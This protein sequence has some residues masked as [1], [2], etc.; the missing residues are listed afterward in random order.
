MTSRQFD[1]LAM[2]G[3]VISFLK[4]TDAATLAKMPHIVALIEQYD[5]MLEELSKQ[6]QIQGLNRTGIRIMKLRMRGELTALTLNI[7]AHMEAYAL[8][9][10]NKVLQYEVALKEYKINKSREN[11]VASLAIII[12]KKALALL[13][14]LAEYGV[15]PQM[16]TD[17][18]EATDEYIAILP[19]TRIGIVTQS[20]STSQIKQLFEQF[21]KLLLRIDKLVTMLRFSNKFF[22]KEYFANRKIIRRGA[23]KNALQ[24]QIL[25]EEGKPLDK[26]TITVVA[27]ATIQSQSGDKG[28]YL[29]RRL[30]G[31]VWPVT[32]SRLGYVSETVFLASVPLVRQE[33]NI[34][35]KR[36]EHVEKT[37]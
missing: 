25:D 15:T 17:L 27:N 12:H 33:L 24:G 16:L 5:E 35:L 13:A 21:D 30:P 1:K 22:Y 9:V 19:K 6:Q 28:N 7:A 2:L 3:A 29:F 23:R 26:V 37:A 4:K 8:S 20:A 11:Y 32:F 18:K 34:V 10:D 36:Q 14:P 31:G